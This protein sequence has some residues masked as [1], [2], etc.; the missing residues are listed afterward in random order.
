M[1]AGGLMKKPK[2]KKKDSWKIG[3]WKFTRIDGIII[4][5]TSH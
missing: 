3:E 5:N 2:S 4:L 1:V